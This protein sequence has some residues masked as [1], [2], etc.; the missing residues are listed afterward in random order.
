MPSPDRPRTTIPEDNDQGTRPPSLASQRSAAIYLQQRQRLDRNAQ[1][2]TI[3]LTGR[4][5]MM[6]RIIFSARSDT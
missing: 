1:Q 3:E 6:C 5:S 2:N 4:I